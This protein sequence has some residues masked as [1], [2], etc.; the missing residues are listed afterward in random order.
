[1]KWEVR[2]EKAS[3]YV[4][5]SKTAVQRNI[6]VPGVVE[7]RAYRTAAGSGQ[8]AATWEFED[9]S[10]WAAW[11]QHETVQKVIE[12]LYPYATNVTTELWTPSPI[13]SKPVRP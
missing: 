13:I 6:S 2:P 12:E 5:W 9:L 11:H 8:V 3:E 1:M 7:F 4:E 10:A